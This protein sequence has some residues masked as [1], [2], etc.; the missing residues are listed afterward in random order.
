MRGP[1][2]WSPSTKLAGLAL[3]ADRDSSLRLIRGQLA[4]LGFF[5]INKGA[6]LSQQQVL[7]FTGRRVD[8]F[9][10]RERRPW[11]PNDRK[12]LSMCPIMPYPVA[13]IMARWHCKPAFS[14]R[15]RTLRVRPIFESYADPVQAPA[16]D[17]C[18]VVEIR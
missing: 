15:P 4:I 2:D 8:Y 17:F 7:A 10:Y 1:T 5:K 18:T 16:H 6:N 11:R 13:A 9:E 14:N 3:V 12:E